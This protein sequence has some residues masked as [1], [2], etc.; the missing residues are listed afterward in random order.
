VWRSEGRDAEALKLLTQRGAGRAG[1]GQSV[2]LLH[3]LA[4]DDV[5]AV[6][7]ALDSWL[8]AGGLAADDLE[9]ALK[10]VVARSE[11]SLAF[12]F[13]EL[14]LLPLTDEMRAKLAV[15]SFDRALLLALLA[16][17]GEQALGGA[18]QAARFALEARDYER[19]EL[20]ASLAL[21]HAPSDALRAIKIEALSALGEHEAALSETRA[22]GDPAL[23]KQLARVQLARLG[24][25]ALAN[26]LDEQPSPEGRGDRK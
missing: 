23:R 11:P 24:L 14:G 21:Q 12:T 19:A 18:E 2:L 13:K 4:H 8:G 10:Q 25:P 20:Y 9:E 17:H 22:L 7:F 15:L 26:A 16:A 3:A 6:R 1:H 5:A